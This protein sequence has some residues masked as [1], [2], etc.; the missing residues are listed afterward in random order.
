[1]KKVLL[2]ALSV[3]SLTVSITPAALAQSR[4]NGV[5]HIN[6]DYQAQIYSDLASNG[7]YTPVNC[8]VPNIVHVRLYD[9]SQNLH[10]TVCFA[11]SQQVP[12]GR[13]TYNLATGQIRQQTVILNPRYNPYYGQPTYNP[14]VPPAPRPPVAPPQQPFPGTVQQIASEFYSLT[15]VAVPPHVQSAL[16]GVAAGQ[17]LSIASCDTAPV[18]VIANN[19]YGFCAYPNAKYG[20]GKWHIQV[21]GLW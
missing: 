15:G 17:D 10:E 14:Q 4:T 21:P 2:S 5:R 11:P 16:R 6:S 8:D 9:A 1:M 7:L 12:P 18:H 3:V 19:T 20:A 13:Y